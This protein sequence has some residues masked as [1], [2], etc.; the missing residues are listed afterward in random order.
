MVTGI[1]AISSQHL[2]EHAA[3]PTSDLQSLSQRFD[4]LMMDDP[5]AL[6][7]N[8]P[9]HNDRDTAA[10]AFVGKGEAMMR[11]TFQG[12][13]NLMLDAPRLNPEE[14][15]VRQMQMSLQVAL[16]QFQ[17]NACAH[18]AQSSKTGMQTLM[19]NQ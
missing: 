5:S 16:A 2:L 12:M 9:H 14:L 4:H 6:Q 15:A 17:F 3:R 19:K 8:R 11:E 18:V 13:H 10:T 7:H 1:E